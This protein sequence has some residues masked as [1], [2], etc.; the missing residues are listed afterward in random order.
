MFFFFFFCVDC[1]PHKAI[2]ETLAQKISGALSLLLMM[3]SVVVMVVFV[4][5]LSL[6]PLIPL[7]SV[8]VYSG[9]IF[10]FF[11]LTIFI[12][13]CSDFYGER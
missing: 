13:S 1:F 4:L 3:L 8:Y 7:F 6:V 5:P 2:D 10:L 9:G 12:L 11:Y